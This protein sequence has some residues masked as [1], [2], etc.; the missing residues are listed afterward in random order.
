V[1]IRLKPSAMTHPV[2]INP[3]NPAVQAAKIALERG[4]GAQPI[5]LPSGGSIPV[6][7]LFKNHLNLET[8]LMGFALPDDGMHAINERFHLPT[9]FR[10]IESC[11]HFYHELAQ[12]RPAR[13]SIMTARS[14]TPRSERFTS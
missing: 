3:Q 11:L 9:F 13:S 5:L 10:A 14:R 8:V 1:R 7:N 12:S 4:F 2:R 6:V